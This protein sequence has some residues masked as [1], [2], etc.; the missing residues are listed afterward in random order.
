MGGS[1]HQSRFF[2]GPPNPDLVFPA[3][4]LPVSAN[5]CFGKCI[6]GLI[7]TL[8]SHYFLTMLLKPKWLHFSLIWPD[9][10]ASLEKWPI[11]AEFGFPLERQGPR[12]ICGFI[13]PK[14]FEQ[15]GGRAG[16]LAQLKKKT[17]REQFSKVHVCLKIWEA[18]FNLQLTYCLQEPGQVTSLL[19]PCL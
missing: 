18:G 8:K 7:K 15:C 13:A 6:P 12:F 14:W 11:V 4:T 10:L 5:S 9:F 16:S 17:G 2:S 3:D 1:G 19:F